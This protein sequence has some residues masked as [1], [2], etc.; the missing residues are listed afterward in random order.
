MTM[1]RVSTFCGAMLLMAAGLLASKQAVAAD[2]TPHSVQPPHGSNKVE[3][4]TPLSLE[5]LKRHLKKFSIRIICWSQADQKAVIKVRNPATLSREQWRKVISES[6]ANKL[7]VKKGS[8]TVVYLLPA[9]VSASRVSAVTG[10]T[11][12]ATDPFAEFDR[13]VLEPVKSLDDLPEIALLQQLWNEEKKSG[14]KYERFVNPPDV[15]SA[16]SFRVEYVP[17][18]QAM[19]PVAGKSSLSQQELTGFPSSGGVLEFIQSQ[20]DWQWLQMRGKSGYLYLTTAEANAPL[21]TVQQN[22]DGHETIAM[23]SAMP[24]GTPFSYTI[25]K[26]GN[27]FTS[28]TNLVSGKGPITLLDFAALGGTP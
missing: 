2:M 15:A 1:I 11:P 24:N 12:P 3:R 9:G 10:Y 13:K 5:Q 7:F 19:M 16:Y 28:T 23:R 20:T 21:F 6:F 22:K 17:Q 27:T 25:V 8:E 18:L 26:T 4:A 14:I